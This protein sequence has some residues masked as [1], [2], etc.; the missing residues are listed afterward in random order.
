MQTRTYG[1]LFKLV[2]SLAGVT[3]FSDNEQDDIANLINRRYQTAFNTSQIWPRYL[4]PSEERSLT[5]FSVSGFGD[6]YNGPYLNYGD[7]A[8]GNPIYIKNQKNA[9]LTSAR[10]SAAFK[11]DAIN[12]TWNLVGGSFS[13]NIETGVVT[14]SSSVTVLSQR[15]TSIE[16]DNPWEVVWAVSGSGSTSMPQ[17]TR[18]QVVEYDELVPAFSS[19]DPVVERETIGEFIRIHSCLLY[20]SDAATTPYV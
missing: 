2:Q 15:D 11:F 6:F 4:V 13:K 7:D 16:Y 17:F 20:T 19:N 3:A 12:K 5:A 9:A 1:D 8:N 10:S 18:V 14:Y